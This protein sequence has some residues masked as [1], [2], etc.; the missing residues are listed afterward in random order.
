MLIAI[1]T[2]NIIFKNSST[3]ASQRVSGEGK[4]AGI[5]KKEKLLMNVVI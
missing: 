4:K 3:S 2:C 1:K 5:G